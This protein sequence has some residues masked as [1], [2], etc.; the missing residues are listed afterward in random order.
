MS[1][2][3]NCG[4]YVPDPYSGCRNC[5]FG[6]NQRSFWAGAL[7]WI[8][9]GFYLAPA[10]I[11][12]Y[13]FHWDFMEAFSA[14]FKSAASWIGSTIF[15]SVVLFTYSAGDPLMLKPESDLA[16]LL[17]VALGFAIFFAY[18]VPK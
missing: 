8:A 7:P 6:Q 16:T 1:Y 10:I 3:P 12:I 5:G 15:W 11:V 18:C 14:A 17:L 4:Q 9:V 13:P 2:C